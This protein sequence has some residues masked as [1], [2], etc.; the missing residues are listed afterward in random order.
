M[1]MMMTRPFNIVPCLCHL[2]DIMSRAEQGGEEGGA[3]GKYFA[4]VIDFTLTKKPKWFAN[5]G[6][7]VF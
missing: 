3:V 4:R 7:E 6:K 2:C 1:M 5:N